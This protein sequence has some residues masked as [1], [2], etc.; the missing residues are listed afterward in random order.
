MR[1]NP[2]KRVSHW[3]A[4]R[5]STPFMLALLLAAAGFFWLFNFSTLPLSNPEL[6]KLSGYEGLLDLMPFYTAREALT[7]LNRY[8]TSGRELYLRFLAVDFIFIPIYGLGFAFLVTRTVRAVCNDGSIWI[9]LNVLPFSIG[10]FDC[11][12][13]LCILV[14]LGLYPDTS[15]ALGTLAGISTVCKH[16]LTLS[17]LLA[18]GYGGLI[19]IVR[20]FG[21]PLCSAHR[22]E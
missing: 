16:V 2:V 19:L 15:E 4:L 10:L 17:V 18:V 7:A 21:F 1:K 22:R 12:E 13:N 5:Y 11:A 6:K 8:G 9:Q 14:M 3:I 20:Q